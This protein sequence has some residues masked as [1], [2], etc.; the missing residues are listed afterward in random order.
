MRPEVQLELD[1][2]VNF[3]CAC[4]LERQTVVFD[5]LPGL[6]LYYGFGE[7]RQ[8]ME[9][10]KPAELKRE[11]L[12]FLEFAIEDMDMSPNALSHE[13]GR[14]IILLWRAQH[15]AGFLKEIGWPSDTRRLSLRST[16]VRLAQIRE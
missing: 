14:H 5:I 6:D 9:Q 10:L 1:D 13:Y 11:L 8:Q 15:R 4:Q 3:L 12:Y 16:A 7:P 2:A